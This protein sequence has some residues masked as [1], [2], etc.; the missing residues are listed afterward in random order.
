MSANREEAYAI[1]GGKNSNDQSKSCTT[2]II[3]SSPKKY[4][5]HTLGLLTRPKNKVETTV[6]DSQQLASQ[7]SFV[8]IHARDRLEVERQKLSYSASYTATQMLVAVARQNQSD[9]PLARFKLD[10]GGSETPCR[11]QSVS[12][13]LRHIAPCRSGACFQVQSAASGT[14]GHV[15]NACVP[16]LN[17]CNHLCARRAT[18]QGALSLKRG[19]Y[20]P[21]S[22][23]CC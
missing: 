6:F 9:A 18:F 4:H 22:S 17:G 2:K 13:V 15:R 12:G 3:P 10:V 7:H 5:L 8:I 20:L 11:P 16:L 14:T 19:M 23:R 21:I 1:S